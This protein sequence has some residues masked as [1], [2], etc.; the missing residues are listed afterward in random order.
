MVSELPACLS[1]LDGFGGLA[2]VVGGAGRT[3]MAPSWSLKAL[4]EWTGAISATQLS[5]KLSHEATIWAS[6]P[7]N[8]L[9]ILGLTILS[10][11]IR[12]QLK[13]LS[14]PGYNK[15]ENSVNKLREW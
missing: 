2:V 12:L 6:T 4:V 11:P 13:S 10:L 5:T 15:G 3:G 9:P 8:S 14:I 7:F 1:H